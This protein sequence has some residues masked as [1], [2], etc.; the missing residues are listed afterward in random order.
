MKIEKKIVNHYPDDLKKQIASEVVTGRLSVY[1]A[2]KKY[3]IGGKMTVFTWVDKFYGQRPRTKPISLSY[4]RKKKL[5]NIDQE[6]YNRLLKE[7]D[8]LEKQLER[9]LLEAGAYQAL[10]DI[11]KE[12]Y[13]L[14]LR[15]KHGTKQS[16][17]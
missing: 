5:K 1:S 7:K 9:S 16:K 8:E 6:E 15:K 12:E 3:G 2:R 14:D 13:N 11:A 10:V 17:D 4:M